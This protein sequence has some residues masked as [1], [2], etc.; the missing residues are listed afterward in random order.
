[1]QAPVFLEQ[2]PEHLVEIRATAPERSPEDAL[3]YGAELAQRAIR[4]AVLQQHTRLETVRAD[5]VER[6]GPD[7]TSRFHE[8]AGAARRG[9]E[10]AFPFA[11]LERGIELP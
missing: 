9:R 3:L 11:G 8:N 4:A 10:H 5:R 2:R 6:K 1:M 7:Q